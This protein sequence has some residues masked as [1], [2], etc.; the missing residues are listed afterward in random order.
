MRLLGLLANV[1]L[2]VSKRSLHVKGQAECADKEQADQDEIGRCNSVGRLILIARTGQKAVGIRKHD[3]VN[4]H[5]SEPKAANRQEGPPTETLQ[6][7][8]DEGPKGKFGNLGQLLFRVLKH[9]HL[10]CL[11][12]KLGVESN[13]LSHLT[14]HEQETN[15]EKNHRQ[16][17]NRH[18]HNQRGLGQVFIRLNHN[19][20][21]DDK[22]NDRSKE[23][24]PC[25][26]SDIGHGFV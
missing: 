23:E 22:Q 17:I 1:L 21:D 18:L 19:N 10:F 20:V 7:K 2:N 26:K 12:H 5:K 13:V 9:G 3:D 11:Q 16:H 25:A 6:T 15:C 24:S 4:D 8:L 14:A